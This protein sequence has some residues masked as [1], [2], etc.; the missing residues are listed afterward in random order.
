MNCDRP[1]DRIKRWSKHIWR[2]CMACFIL[3]G[4]IMAVAIPLALVGHTSMDFRV[5]GVSVKVDALVPWARFLLLALVA[6][7]GGLVMRALWHLMRLFQLF[8]EGEI[9]SG[10]TVGRL[11]R[12]GKTLLIYG[13]IQ[14]FGPVVLVPTLLFGGVGGFKFNMSFDALIAAG[15]IMVL[16][17][18]MEEGRK[19]H[20]DQQLTV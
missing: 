11:Q 15:L 7:C 4:L 16:S 8:A 20:E 5:M 10:R 13:L 3:L 9:F 14:V 1:A 18:V 6:L 19:L 2:L 17:W 12:I